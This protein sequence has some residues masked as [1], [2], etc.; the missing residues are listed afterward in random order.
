MN[1]ML[2]N[3]LRLPMKIKP[4][5]Q[6]DLPFIKNTLTNIKLINQNL[7]YPPLIY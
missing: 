4:I 1:K 7:F 6:K 3:I 5:F 2:I